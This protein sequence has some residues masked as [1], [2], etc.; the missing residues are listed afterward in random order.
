M[1]NR[2]PTQPLTEN[3]VKTSSIF[4]LAGALTLAAGTALVARVLMRPPPPVT[5]IKQVAVPL[6]P[7]LMVLSAA[8][9]LAP[10]DFIDPSMLAWR[11]TGAQP[12]ADQISAANDTERLEHE[13]ALLGAVVRMPLDTDTP[14]TRGKLVRTGEAG[15]LA[16]VL[17]PG[18]RAMSIPTSALSSNA[19]LVQAGDHVDVILSL[20]RG[21]LA[22]TDEGANPFLPLAAQT[23]LR[24][25]RVLALNSSTSSIAPANVPEAATDKARQPANTARAWFET[26]TLEVPPAAAERLAVAKEIGTLQVALRGARE[27]EDGDHQP[28]IADRDT[29]VTRLGDTTAI[30][31]GGVKA[32]KAVVEAY[33]G[34]AKTSVSFD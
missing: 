24:N 26:L 9:P 4:L 15:F 7:D 32:R 5:I 13:R 2:A 14:F 18:M 34:R 6:R 27:L 33:Q 30:F 23:I 22:S 25:V 1:T 10:G 19:G 16:A 17:G 28:S 29:G 20:Q 12:T 8:R 3:Y 31:A 21:A 11:K